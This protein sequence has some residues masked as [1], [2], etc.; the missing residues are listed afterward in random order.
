M[1]E[2]ETRLLPI[3]RCAEC[4]HCENVGVTLAQ[5]GVTRRYFHSYIHFADGFPPDCPLETNAHNDLVKRQLVFERDC[6][7]QSERWHGGVNRKTWREDM[8]FYRGLAF[9]LRPER[10]IEVW[11]MVRRCNGME[12][13]ERK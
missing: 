3:T 9:G 5:C 11:A 6:R 8:W 7:M 12:W 4:H 10:R 13:N 1:R 2:I